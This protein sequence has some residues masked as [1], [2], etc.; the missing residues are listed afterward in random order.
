MGSCNSKPTEEEGSETSG[1]RT[2]RNKNKKR[3]THKVVLVGDKA[4]GKSSLVLRYTKDQFQ[5]AHALTIGAAFVSKDPALLCL[6]SPCL[7]QQKHSCFFC[8]LCQ[9]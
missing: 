7:Y 6:L 2:T 4:V 8:P 1:I 3:D 9:G 5:E